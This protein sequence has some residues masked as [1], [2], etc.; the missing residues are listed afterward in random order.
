M[1][2]RN[3]ID[4][5]SC[6]SDE[7]ESFFLFRDTA[8]TYIMLHYGYGVGQRSNKYPG[9]FYVALNNGCVNGY[10]VVGQIKDSRNKP[11]L[12]LGAVNKQGTDD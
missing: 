11:S 8:G 3:V 5:R 7:S 2:L 6:L 9:L 1:A 10:R 12:M 4:A